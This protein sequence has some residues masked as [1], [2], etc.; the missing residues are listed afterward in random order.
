MP[1]L[2][3]LVEEVSANGEP[4]MLRRAANGTRP[5]DAIGITRGRRKPTEEDM[6]AVYF[7]AGGWAGFDTDQLI[8]DVHESR[9]YA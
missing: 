3:A 6:E 1:E 2:L 4:L 9:R 7:A 5:V 8:A